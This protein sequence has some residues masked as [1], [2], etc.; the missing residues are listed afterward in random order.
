MAAASNDGVR[1]VLVPAESVA[2][3]AGAAGFSGGA[4]S[5]FALVGAEP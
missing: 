5:E 1:V 2:D 3:R 4:V